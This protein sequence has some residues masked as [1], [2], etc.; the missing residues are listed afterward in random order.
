MKLEKIISRPPSVLGSQ[1]RLLYY[2]QG[3]LALP[4]LIGNDWLEPLRLALDEIVEKSR[5]YK[6]ST[7]KVD[8]E[9]NHS[10]AVPRLRRVAYLDDISPIFWKLC[11]DS[12]IPDIAADLLGPNVCF[13]EILV[14]FKWADGG[15]EVKWHQDIAF[16]P[17]THSGSLQ[18]L[19]MLEDTRLEQGPLQV[20]PGS[21]KNTVFAHYDSQ[22]NWTGAISEHELSNIPLDRAKAITG[23]AGTVSVHHSQTIHGSAPNFSDQNRP[24]FVVTYTA[25][26][27][28]PYTAPAYPSSRYRQ[29]V[30]GKSPGVAHHEEMVIPLPPDWS[31]G[32]TSIFEHQEE[33]EVDHAY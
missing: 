28:I 13:R 27:A 10:Y 6:K 31:G 3:Y 24:A 15:A 12:I 9:P 19:L 14:N 1:D 5:E 21:H 26:D 4:G 11:S 8:L 30:R 25:A 29:L 17:H 22:G 16:Y 32:Y 20:V 18:F 2:E 33:K 23:P 7:R